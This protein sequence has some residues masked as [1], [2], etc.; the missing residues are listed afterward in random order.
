[1]KSV[2]T[3]RIGD[4][5]IA[6]HSLNLSL[7][8]SGCGLGFITVLT[9]Q[10]C[11]GKLVRLDLGY[12][13]SIYRWLTGF[14]ERSAPAENGAQ[15]LMV[16]ELVGVFERSWPCSLQ[17]PTLRD[18]TDTVGKAT[19]MRFVLPENTAYT[20]TPIPHFQHN[21]SGSQLML[22]LGRAFSIPDYVWY[23][24]P[25]GTVYVGSY[26]D[27]RFAQTPVDIPQD[28]AQGGGGGNSLTLP[29]IP[30]IRPG[31]IVNGRRITKVDV[32]DDTMTLNWTPLN[33][34]GQPAQKSPEQRQIE[35]L[36]PELGAGLHLP[37]RARV[38]SPTDA[39]ELG[40]P[41][42]PFR[43]RYAVNVQLLDENGN[44]AAGTQEYNAVPLPIPMAG[45]EGGMFQ[46]PPE[47]TLVEIGFADGRPDK[48]MIRQILS[49]GLS[50]PAVKP[51]EQL[52]QQRAGVSQRVTV[53]G[54]W[55]RDTDQAIEETSSRRSVT[56]DEEKRTTTTRNTTV[57]ANDSTTVLGTKTLMAGQVVQLAE[58][59]YSIGTSANMVTKVSKDKTD[60]VGQNQNT[61]VGQNLTTDVAGSLTEKITG[62]RRS[63]AAAQELIAPSV[64]LGTDEINVLT[65][66]TDTLDVIQTLAQQ[67]ASHTHNNTGGPLNAGDF[68]ATA[69]RTQALT[70]KYSP[71]IA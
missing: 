4:D 10:N 25:D 9:E 26:A 54:S 44:A 56:S 55:Q 32:S 68:T 13:A 58:G 21:G 62:I 43:P 67:T 7:S 40:D 12:N 1:M 8:L 50:L 34:Q 17:H 27:S 28:F 14:V 69:N 39:A 18:V 41:S 20:D 49:E 45:S 6:A 51:G 65:L 52:Q 48:P 29:L 42:D 24:L 63:V 31:V 46:F 71:F 19:S 33:T 47:G 22:N 37:R 70:N 61:K 11:I 66:L 64:R 36:Y 16:R 30:A 60:D 59:D 3:L 35:K 38:M 53:D 57:K 23:Q 5:E 15:R 2:V